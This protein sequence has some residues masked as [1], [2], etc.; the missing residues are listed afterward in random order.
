[1][2]YIS[3][4]NKNNIYT[5][6][7]A[8]YQGLAADGGLLL[9]EKIPSITIQELEM[10]SGGSYIDI[11]SKIIVRYWE[12]LDDKIL[13]VLLSKSYSTFANKQ[14][15]PVIKLGEFY[16]A[17]LFYGPTLA[18][19]DLAMQFLGNLLEYINIEDGKSINILGATSG[20]TGSAA[21]YS[22]KGKEH[23]KIFILYPN[24]AISKIQELQMVTHNDRNIEAIAVEGSFD[25]C[26]DILKSIF[27]D[28]NFKKTYNIIAVNSIN[29]VRILAQV[30]Y[31]FYIYLSIVKKR[32]IGK[33]LN[34]SVPTGNFGNVFAGY[35]AKKMGL[36]IDKLVIATNENDILK[37]FVSNGVYE[38]KKVTKTYS[39]S[40]D[41]TVASN[42]ERYLYYLL[43]ENDSE[44]VKYMDKLKQVSRVTV[45]K[46]LLEKVSDDFFAESTSNMETIN[47]IVEV[48]KKYNY[49]V[50]PHTA[51]GV[52][53]YW[54]LSEFLKTDTVCLATAHHAKFPEV[55]E[56][57]IGQNISYPESIKE[58]FD[59]EKHF[60]VFSNDE[61]PVKDYILKKALV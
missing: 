32:E 21:I 36:P 9:P 54:K 7:D 60:T 14:I 26:Q 20:D 47:T 22:V 59:K 2:N 8:L 25:D 43:D 31:Y 5:F 53:A 56:R 13:K 49:I 30:V 39:P 55:V 11:A 1:M 61:K 40:M 23:I 58:L 16:I 19:K 42:F 3:T 29:W 41:I 45:D 18:F 28:N 4:R 27:M 51:C 38:I 50:D 34:F 57:A 17:E 44:V 46:S 48:F 15:V 10:M 24:R 52:N 35:I 6:K 33:L 12:D 37:N